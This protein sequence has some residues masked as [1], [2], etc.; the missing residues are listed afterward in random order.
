MATTCSTALCETRRDG[1]KLAALARVPTLRQLAGQ[2]LAD[3]FWAHC[4]LPCSH[5]S[6]VP[7]AAVIAK[8]GPQVTRVCGVAPDLKRHVVIFLEIAHVVIVI[9]TVGIVELFSLQPTR[10]VRWRPNRPCETR[11]AYR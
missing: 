7:W 3:W 5:S 11:N 2:D 10:V 1:F 8:L 6:A 4:P 9:T